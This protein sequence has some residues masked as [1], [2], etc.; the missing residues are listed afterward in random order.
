MALNKFL[1]DNRG[2]CDT[3]KKTAEAKN[4]ITSLK[5]NITLKT[6]SL[7]K[8]AAV[9]DKEKKR[10]S[11]NI[12]KINGEI[13]PPWHLILPKCTSAVARDPL[14]TGVTRD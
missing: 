2:V 8:M 14:H 11:P 4:A 12:E 6:N 1:C 9:V 10:P 13:R 7:E 3:V 5:S